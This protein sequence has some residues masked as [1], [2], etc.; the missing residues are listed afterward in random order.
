[1]VYLSGLLTIL[2]P[3]VAAS[4]FNAMTTAYNDLD[5]HHTGVPNPDTLGLRT[6]EF[7]EYHKTGRLGTHIDSGSH[8]SISIA[9]GNETAYDGGYFRLETEQAMFKV[10]QQSAVVFFS[11]RA[12]GVTPI[13]SGN[14]KVFVVEIWDEE[15]LPPGY[16]RSDPEHFKEYK[17]R[18]AQY[19][20]DESFVKETVEKTAD[21]NGKTT[22]DKEL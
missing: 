11:E 5:W 15:D 20:Q 16:G 2:L 17:D 22:E 14:R 7:L 13:H 6:A 3:G 1:M 12:H 4:I 9:L 10:P 8:F 18:F 21:S 19:E